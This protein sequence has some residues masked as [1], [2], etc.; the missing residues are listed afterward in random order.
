MTENCSCGVCAECQWWQRNAEL[1]GDPVPI[2]EI[3]DLRHGLA[4]AI[5]LLSARVVEE[6][7]LIA[8]SKAAD[9]RYRVE[10]D[11]D[12]RAVALLKATVPG[13]MRRWVVDEKNDEKYWAISPEWTGPLASKLRNAGFEIAGLDE[14]NIADWFSCFLVA[15]PTSED[16]HRAYVKGMCKTCTTAPHRPGGVE[17]DGCFRQR[18]IDQH[19]VVSILADK[20]L[21]PWP[22]VEP[23]TGKARTTRAPLPIDRSE[24]EIINRDFTVEVDFAILAHRDQSVVRP[25]CPI[26]GRRPAKGAVVHVGCRTR[27]LHACNDRPFLKARSKAFQAGLC[28]VCMTRPHRLP[29]RIACAHCAELI[30]DVY[31]SKGIPR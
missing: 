2:G 18:L 30:A 29:G 20:G 17:C 24:I 9:G 11:Y 4:N 7:P 5:A 3:I 26:C 31:Q 8:F 14:D 21:A 10:F 23:A 25:P 12:T 19:R 27:L 13:S 22:E 28:T 6:Q 1:G 16:G 15:T